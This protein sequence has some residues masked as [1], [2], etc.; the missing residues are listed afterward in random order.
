MHK[1]TNYL[2]YRNSPQEDSPTPDITPQLSQKTKRKYDLPDY[3]SPFVDCIIKI[4]QTDKRKKNILALARDPL[5]KI[6]AK[7]QDEAFIRKYSN[8]LA[9]DNEP[10]WIAAGYLLSMI[11]KNID[12][13]HHEIEGKSLSGTEGFWDVS[14][15][16]N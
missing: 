7:P 13:K 1:L 10:F 14:V 8:I 11:V 9:N 15:I 16:V 5:G 6:T 12:I 2:F 4:L 3:S